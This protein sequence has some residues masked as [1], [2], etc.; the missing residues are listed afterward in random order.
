MVPSSDDRNSIDRQQGAPISDSASSLAISTN[1]QNSA[2]EN[3]GHVAISP[4]GAQPNPV[5]PEIAVIEKVRSAE[6]GKSR[7]P[8]NERD[9]KLTLLP[10]PQKRSLYT[11]VSKD[12]W[13]LELITL[14]L[15]IVLVIGIVILLR[16]YDGRQLPKWP[17]GLTLNTVVSIL[18]N[19][20]SAALTGS[21]AAGISQLKWLWYAD[22]KATGRRLGDLQLFDEASRGSLGC[23]KLLKRGWKS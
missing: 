7:P 18:S 15:S 2:I 16:V 10:S 9:E 19:F 5:A 4:G 14:F 23:L 20:A 8:Y 12:G 22:A 11:R 1:S 17:Y 13:L 21:V 6:E 3:D